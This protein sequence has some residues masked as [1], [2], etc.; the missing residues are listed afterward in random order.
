[1][2]LDGRSQLSKQMRCWTK[3][4]DKGLDLTYIS[5]SIICP[6]INF[7]NCSKK[8]KEMPNVNMDPRGTDQSRDFPFPS[9]HLIRKIK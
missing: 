6:S 1:M 5:I 7:S 4:N 9:P 2:V 8:S 3:A